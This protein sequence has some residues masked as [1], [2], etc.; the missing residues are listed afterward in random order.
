M[1]SY[2]H[3][4][5]IEYEAVLRLSD[6][7]SI[8]AGQ[9]VSKILVKNE[10]LSMRLFALDK[11]TEIGAH[12]S[13]GDALVTVIEG[14]GEFIVDGKRYLV[15]AGESLVMPA[16][17]PHSIFAVECFKMFLVVVFPQPSTGVQE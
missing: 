12:D 9:V 16:K 3:I 4:K 8:V 10:A 7:T 14:I 5:S 2:K 11:G 15:H 13:S 17:K 6:Q 1:M